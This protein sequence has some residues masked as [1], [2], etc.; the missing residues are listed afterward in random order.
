MP[1]PSRESV[2]SAI[3]VIVHQS[4][5]KDGGRRVTHVTE[6]VG[7]EGE[8]ITLQ[9][10]FLCDF[11]MGFDAHGVFQG[12]LRST[13]LRPKVVDRLADHG[14]GV[15]LGIFGFERFAR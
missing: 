5:F 2:A 7:M 13:G 15:D 8:V 6:V 1:G 3:D 14:V 4:R 11:G 12:A 10:V 9:D